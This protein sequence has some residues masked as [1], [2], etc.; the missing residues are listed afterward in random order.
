MS[1]NQESDLLDHTG[2]GPEKHEIQE[3]I[4]ETQTQGK[5]LEQ[6]NKLFS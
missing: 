5:K 1:Q 3:S 2:I 4:M 6:E